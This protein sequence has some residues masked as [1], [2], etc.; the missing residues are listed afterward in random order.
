MIEIMLEN[1]MK[2]FRLKSRIERTL[3]KI[4]SV[5]WEFEKIP[6]VIHLSVF[7][8]GQ[9]NI[10]KYNKKYR[11]KD[12]PT[13]ILSFSLWEGEKLAPPIPYPLGDLFLCPHVINDNALSQGKSFHEELEDILI[14]GY[15]HL[16]GYDHEREKEARLMRRREKSIKM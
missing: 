11:K 4:H 7:V 13:D 10:R 12:K 9:K 5:A 3:Q 16:L 14:H 2:K 15:L 1:H 6:Q 8:V